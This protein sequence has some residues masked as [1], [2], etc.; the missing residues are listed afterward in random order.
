MGVGQVMPATAKALAQRLGLPNR[1]DLMAGNTPDARK[2]QDAITEAALQEAWQ[3]T[4]GDL[5]R[6]AMYYYGGSNTGLW[7][8]KT[9]RY[10]DEV[11]S[12]IGAG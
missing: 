9:R 7:G 12:R 4:G 1:P 2:Y 11:L 10:A 5:R 6:A 8:P 3:A